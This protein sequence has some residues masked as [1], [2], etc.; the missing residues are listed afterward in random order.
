MCWWF[1]DWV[2]ELSWLL[3]VRGRSNTSPGLG[4]MWRSGGAR[5]AIFRPLHGSVLSVSRS[6][7]AASR[8]VPVAGKG[9]VGGQKPQPL[10]HM[11]HHGGES[12]GRLN[13]TGWPACVSHAVRHHSLILRSHFTLYKHENNLPHLR[14]LLT[15]GSVF[16]SWPSL[17]V[18]WD[19]SLTYPSDHFRRL[20]QKHSSSRTKLE[21]LVVFGAFLAVQPCNLVVLG[22]I[23]PSL[24][25][26]IVSQVLCLTCPQEDIL[27][28]QLE[29]LERFGTMLSLVL[30]FISCFSCFPALSGGLVLRWIVKV[31]MREFKAPIYFYCY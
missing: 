3:L 16:S 5:G 9:P 15:S 4:G 10:S 6:V 28:Q 13:V 19:S 26:I 27:K 2:R 21:T 12:Q 30:I 11:F 24:F 17:Q 23:I 20:R 1:P 8:L 31:P 14:G 18:E 22:A 29:Q 25:I 7:A